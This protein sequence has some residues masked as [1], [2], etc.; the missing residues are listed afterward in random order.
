MRRPREGPARR[1]GTSRGGVDR[2]KFD[3]GIAQQLGRID[4]IAQMLATSFLQGLRRSRRHGFSSEFSEFKPYVPGDDLRLLDWRVYARSGKLFV[5]RFE[6]ETELE[7]LMI[8]DATASMAW[9]WEQSITK[10]QYG[11]NLLAAIACI[12]MRHQDRA[13]L[14]VHDAE[15]L[16]YLPPRCRREQLDDIFNVLENVRPGGGDS[17][18][19]LIEGLAG[20]KR[21]RGMLI[22]CSDLEEDEE[23]T[24]LALEML[25]LTEDRACIIH[26]LDKAE[27]DIPFGEVTHLEDSE[28]GERVA[29]D[30]GSLRKGHDRTVSDFRGRWRALSD[31]LGIGYRPVHTG[32]NYL[33]VLLG[34]AE[35]H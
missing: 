13:G 26:L 15:E 28:T 4:L 25:S 24:A 7:H 14:M 9:Q 12:C 31:R 8:L 3:P 21:H 35:M 20:A 33:D 1:D 10:L 22:I 2:S 5:R 18:P 19:R 6:A 23:G 32:M 30:I 16:H 29:A 27:E 17:L 11:A 34:I